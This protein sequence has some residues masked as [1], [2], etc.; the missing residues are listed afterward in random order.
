MN[1]NVVDWF[2]IPVT[3]MVRA[4]TF[5]STVFGKEL[6]NMNMPEM[7]MASFPWFNDA[8][9]APG[10]LVKSK[11]YEPTATGTVV[12]FY[13]EDVNVELAKA[14][15]SGGKVIVPKTDIGEYGFIALFID[16]EGNRV[17]LHSAK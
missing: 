12:Y 11:G 6:V 1:K 10:S 14:I 3:D 8:E 4:K 9:N 15:K 7:E 16:T 5:Y 2:E 17:G 13:S